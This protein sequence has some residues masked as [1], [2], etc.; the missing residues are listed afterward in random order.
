MRLRV[1]ASVNA[2]HGLFYLTYHWGSDR[3][4]AC[5]PWMHLLPAVSF[6]L[7]RA[8]F[9]PR[10]RKIHPQPLGWINQPTNQQKPEI[11][12]KS[13]K[14]TLVLASA[15]IVMPLAVTRVRVDLV[16]P[17]WHVFERWLRILLRRM[18]QHGF[19]VLQSEQRD[20]LERG[21][22]GAHRRRRQ[23]LSQHRAETTSAKP[24]A[25]TPPQAAT[26][27]ARPAVRI[28]T[29]RLTAGCRPK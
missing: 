18:G 3:L 6:A 7:P 29:P 16:C 21:Q 25:P 17:V 26:T 1:C 28:G 22:L 20:L 24:S 8:V 19:G 12:M 23:G 9:Y 5:H 10:G 27:G 2:I 11:H 13:M 15:A 14:L 4:K